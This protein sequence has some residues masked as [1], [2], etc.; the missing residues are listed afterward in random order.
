MYVELRGWH[1]L[2]QAMGKGP[3]TARDGAD[4]GP[5][6][7]PPEADQVLEHLHLL[8]QADTVDL[9]WRMHA[10]MMAR[11]GFDRLL[12]AFTPFLVPGRPAELEDV[13]ILST[14]APAYLEG[15]IGGGLYRHSMMLDWALQNSGPCSWSVR[16]RIAAER[17]LTPA[18]RRTMDFNRAMGVLAGYLVSFAPAGGRGRAVISLCARPGLEQTEVD[19]I[20]QC[21]NRPLTLLNDIMHL[22]LSTLPCAVWRRKLTRRQR[23]AL[24]LSSE[25]RTTQQIATLMGV[26]LA[27]AEKHLRLARDALGVDTTTQAVLKAAAM[28]QIFVAGQGDGAD[29]AETPITARITPDGSFDTQR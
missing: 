14:H 24:E 6:V 3:G 15:Y 28:R 2:L 22:R 29:H 20:W 10:A 5:D 19:A 7:I 1:G 23:E 27:T 11:F 12:Y 17:P 18:Q 21:H 9:V 25:G 13:L 16:Q 4:A 26:S 8:M